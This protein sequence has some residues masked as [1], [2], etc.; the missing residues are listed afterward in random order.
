[1]MA[2]SRSALAK[3]ESLPTASSSAPPTRAQLPSGIVEAGQRT[4]PWDWW[5]PASFKFVTAHL[6]LSKEGFHP[7]ALV[8]ARMIVQAIHKRED[9]EGEAWLPCPAPDEDPGGTYRIVSIYGAPV[10]KRLR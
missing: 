3:D 5:R 8:L 4:P 9:L 10:V 6:H 7:A 1:M 2:K